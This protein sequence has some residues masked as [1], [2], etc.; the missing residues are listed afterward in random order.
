MNALFKELGYRKFYRKTARL[1][2][3]GAMSCRFSC[4]PFDLWGGH[5]ISP[6]L[7]LSSQGMRYIMLGA[8]GVLDIAWMCGG[9]R[10]AADSFPSQA[11]R[12]GFL[13]RVNF[14]ELAQ[15]IACGW[16]TRFLKRIGAF[17]QSFAPG[18]SLF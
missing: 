10:P 4:Y 18:P 14:R 3:L 9:G 17:L 1:R 11:S 12:H 16:D 5:S 8:D 7:H 15:S 6:S 13:A 2:C